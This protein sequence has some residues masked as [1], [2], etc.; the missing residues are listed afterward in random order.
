MRTLQ[1]LAEAAIQL[2][3]KIEFLTPEGFASVPL[4]TY[5]GLRLAI[6]SLAEIARRID[7]SKPDAV[8]IA[9]EG[10]IGI[11]LGNGPD[12]QCARRRARSLVKHN[13]K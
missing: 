12:V 5:P 9:T 8:Q 6:P 10:P 11:A 1:S 7:R 3:A 2:G 4:P 13:G